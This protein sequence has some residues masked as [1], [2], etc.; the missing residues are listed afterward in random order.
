MSHDTGPVRGQASLDSQTAAPQPGCRHLPLTAASAG[1]KPCFLE[2]PSCSFHPACLSSPRCRCPGSPV[3]P[4]SLQ[5]PS[6]SLPRWLLFIPGLLVFVHQI[7][8]N[9]SITG[10]PSKAC[11]GPGTV[12]GD[13]DAKVKEA[14]LRSQRARSHPHGKAWSVYCRKRQRTCGLHDCLVV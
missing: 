7:I 10:Q 12:P 14:G 13:G 6:K 5:W 4:V 11:R 8:I 2:S 1:L 9:Q 3:N